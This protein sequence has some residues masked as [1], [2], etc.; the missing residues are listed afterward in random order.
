MMDI[1]AI[2]AASIVYHMSQVQQGVATTSQMTQ[3]IVTDNGLNTASSGAAASSSQSGT[4]PGTAST[5]A[6]SAELEDILKQYYDTKAEVSALSVDLAILDADFRIGKIESA[7]FQEQKS[8][9]G[10]TLQVNYERNIKMEKVMHICCFHLILM[11]F[12]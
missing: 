5:P 1:N 7:A 3:P 12:S 11:I 10:L 4:A 9:D 2:S 6:S 8:F